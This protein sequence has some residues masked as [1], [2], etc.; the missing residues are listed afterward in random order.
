MEETVPETDRTGPV[1]RN[2]Y[3]GELSHSQETSLPAVVSPSLSGEA[4]KRKARAVKS[5]KKMSSKSKTDKVVDRTDCV[6][7]S[8]TTLVRCAASTP[9]GPNGGGWP[10]RK[11]WPSPDQVDLL[12]QV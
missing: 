2:G 3:G 10:G 5:N 9:T 6:M 12:R 7:I 4:Q 8:N 11:A 1:L